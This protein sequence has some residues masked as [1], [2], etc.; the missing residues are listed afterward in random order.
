MLRLTSASSRSAESLLRRF[1]PRDRAQAIVGDL[2]ETHPSPTRF[3][4]AFLRISVAFTWRPAAALL[5]ALLAAVLSSVA[6]FFATASHWRSG[7]VPIAAL[8]MKYIGLSDLSGFLFALA[9]YAL[10]R[11]GPRDYIWLLS[12]L[13]VCA[14][15]ICIYSFW[16]PHLRPE[17]YSALALVASASTR[18]LRHSA[19]VIVISS[20]A[21]L[22]ANLLISALAKATVQQWRVLWTI[23]ALNLLPVSII[24]FVPIISGL[25][26]YIWLHRHVPASHPT[27]A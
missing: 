17:L 13:Y 25:T 23:P 21:Y 16:L 8:M 5:V 6:L 11:Y 22:A 27:A 10:V 9:A 2:L 3:W 20:S 12:L 4:F 14:G 26:A 1:V 19:A 18:N 7:H 15:S 24:T